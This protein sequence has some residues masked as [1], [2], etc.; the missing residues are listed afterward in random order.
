MVPEASAGD[1]GRRGHPRAGRGSSRLRVETLR[2]PCAHVGGEDPIPLVDS[3]LEAP[4]ETTELPEPIAGAPVARPRSLHPYLMQN[5][6]DRDRVDT[7]LDCIVL[8]NEYVRAQFLPQLGGRLWSL[9]DLVTGR[10]LLYRNGA[11]QPAN[12]ALRNAWFAGGVEWNIATKGHA[13]HTA[14]PLHAA[15]V[16]GP[17]NV[18][19]L[20]MWEFERVRRVVFQVDARLPPGSKAL[21]VHVRIRNPNADAVPM[22]WWSNAA[23]PERMDVRVIAPATRAYATGTDGTV[24]VVP[25]PVHESSDR[26][27][28][29]HSAYTADTFFDLANRSR[30]WIA[31]VDASGH[32][33]GHVSTDR[34]IG[35]KLF[36]WGNGT[37]GRRWQRWLSPEGGAY[38]EIQAGLA[39]TQ[40]E[41]IMMPASGS[42]SW[43]EAYGDVAADPTICHGDDWAAVTRHLDERMDRLAGA[44]A[45]AEALDQATAV[46]DV[47]PAAMLCRGSGW[48]ALERETRTVAGE[49]WVS[50]SGTPFATD[51]MGP[52]QQ[53]WRDLLRGDPSAGTALLHADP[54]T[55]PRSYVMGEVWKRLLSRS[56]SS[57]ARDYHLGV[58]AHARGDLVAAHQFYSASVAE[59][60]TAWALRGLA[61]IAREKGDL[62]AA[63]DLLGTA[64]ARA[65]GEPSIMVEAITVA[66]E[67]GDGPAAWALVDRAPP[68]VREIGRVR[69]LEARAALACGAHPRV[70]QLLASAIVVPD[71]REGETSLSDLWL[72]MYPD[73]PLPAEYDFRMC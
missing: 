67:A 57:W 31:A 24:R 8:E 4:L 70:A 47:P 17:D 9:V 64:A 15:L 51:T 40:L 63:A 20:R 60:P 45:L 59:Q 36:C 39:A 16:T 5:R 68:G 2:I 61:R 38:L 13:P 22:Y 54:R 37:G 71:L 58:L 26:T 42:W 14:S 27:W 11:I 55:P 3:L 10:E 12:L 30:P 33:L 66:L 19:T 46:A 32:G 28:P 52:D 35:R 29:A 25:I 69:L 62:P 49:G 1:S 34:L 73:E 72:Q 53:V 21:Y 41:H 7:E 44:S 6:Y 18:P 56:P 43:V 23:V 65:P 48:G 50:E